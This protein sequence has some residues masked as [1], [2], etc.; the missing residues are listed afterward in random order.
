[1]ATFRTTVSTSRE[2]PASSTTI[3]LDT[4]IRIVYPLLDSVIN[5]RWRT[6]A[7]VNNY[8]FNLHKCL[9]FP[10]VAGY[11]SHICPRNAKMTD[12]ARH[13]VLDWH[14]ALRSN[15]AFGK[16]EDG[17]G[18]YAPMAKGMLKMVHFNSEPWSNRVIWALRLRPGEK[19]SG[20]SRTLSF[21]SL[22]TRKGR[23]EYVPDWA[24]E[25]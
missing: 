7:K 8:L 20:G 15:L 17:E 22:Q 4:R 16:E 1:M 24:G 25:Y 9:I 19:C 11:T 6:R 2:L 12:S 13:T 10:E 18:A 23:T 14:N 21:H 3:A 5:A